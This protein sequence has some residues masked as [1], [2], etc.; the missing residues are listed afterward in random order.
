MSNMDE[1]ARYSKLANET[2][3]DAEL[4]WLKEQGATANTTA[5]AW[6]ELLL[7]AGYSGTNND[8]YKKW[9]DDG[10]QFG[11]QILQLLWDASNDSDPY[12]VVQDG[13][14]TLAAK[15]TISSTRVGVTDVELTEP[16]YI[17]MTINASV[18]TVVTGR[19]GLALI[20]GKYVGNNINLATPYF[21]MMASTSS[22]LLYSPYETQIS[23]PYTTWSGTPGNI[24]KVA[25]HPTNGHIWFGFN[26]EWYNGGDPATG[27]NPTFTVNIPASG[28]YF[29]GL[30]VY[31]NLSNVLPD[32]P[33]FT[34]P[35][36]F[37]AAVTGA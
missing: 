15:T 35:S 29:A 37:K 10:G 21:R 16:V 33:Q 19:N 26:G 30:G 2:L 6:K 24:L 32:T 8:M 31:S 12:W 20:T 4:R 5:D 27:L 3:Q 11:P 1:A 22:W 13:G 14:S 7:G 17:E 36:G 28:L 23:V 18:G 34:I 9:L 25:Y